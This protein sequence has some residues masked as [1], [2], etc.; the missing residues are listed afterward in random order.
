RSRGRCR[1]TDEALAAVLVELEVRELALVEAARVTF[2]PGL[3][4]LTGETGSGKSL[5][6]DAL[7]LALGDRASTDQVRQGASRASVE[8]RFA[9]PGGELTPARE[10]GGRGAARIDGKAAS[11]TPRRELG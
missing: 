6:V 11:P 4:L 9:V 1:A 8:A 7:G 2:G 3:N 5:I 10:G